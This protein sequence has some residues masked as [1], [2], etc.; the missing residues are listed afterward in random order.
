MKNIYLTLLLLLT[1]SVTLAQRPE[2]SILNFRACPS[3]NGEVAL[4]TD[5]QF[6]SDRIDPIRQS[7]FQDDSRVM[8]SLSYCMGFS[9]SIKNVSDTLLLPGLPDGYYQFRVNLLAGLH[10]YNSQ[11]APL[12]IDVARLGFHVGPWPALP[13]ARPQEVYELCEGDTVLLPGDENCK[14]VRWENGDFD[15]Y[16]LV[17]QPGT[18]VATYPGTGFPPRRDTFQVVS[19]R[20]TSVAEELGFQVRVAPHPLQTTAWVQV[21]YPGNDRLSYRLFDQQ[22][23]VVQA[24]KGLAKH[25]RL[26]RGELPAGMYLLELQAGGF[27]AFHK[28]LMITD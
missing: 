25:F 6:S 24:E 21:D 4:I 19:C 18:Y 9:P 2:G 26:Q 10:I 23:K 1:L 3:G 28:K 12:E 15:P 8:L 13:Q 5:M 17:T 14:G 11:C 7:L 20:A 27:P 16:R 22:G